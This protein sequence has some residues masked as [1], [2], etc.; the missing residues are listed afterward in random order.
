MSEKPKLVNI[1]MVRDN[2]DDVRDYPL[3]RPYKIRLYRPGDEKAFD[4]IWLAADEFGQART[5]LFQAEFG[6][7]LDEVPRRMFFILDGAGKPVGTA[8]AWFNDKFDYDGKPYGVVHWVAIVPDQQGK[9]LAKPLMS[10]VLKRMKELGHV[11]ALLVTQ[12]VRLAAI[13]LYLG[14]GFKPLVK[15]ADDAR[16]WREVRDA[17]G[18]GVTDETDVGG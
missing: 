13:N 1:T 9:G 3:P 5:G 14:F 10:T 2:L 7:K 18:G 12:T 17:L 15:N 16:A 11:R 8:T 6:G 4:E